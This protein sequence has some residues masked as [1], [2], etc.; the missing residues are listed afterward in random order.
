MTPCAESSDT[1][2]R[3]RPVPLLLEGL[4]RLEYRGYD[5]AGIAMVSDGGVHDPPLAGQARQPRREA[6]GSARR[7][8]HRH[9]PHA[10]GDPRPAD[11]ANAHPQTDCTGK[12]VVVHNGIFENFAE[13]KAALAKAGHKFAS[14]TDTEVFAHQVEAA[15]EGDLAR[16]GAA[17]AVR[18]LTGAYAVLVAGSREPGVLVAAR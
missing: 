15:F 14:E 16:G 18:R 5:S 3:A 12:I 17:R 9:R 4:K 2:V 6:G 10:L 1:W 11:R 13:L 7:G 8:H